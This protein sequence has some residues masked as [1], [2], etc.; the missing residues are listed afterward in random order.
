MFENN[1]V[2]RSLI[3]LEHHFQFIVITY[4]YVYKYVVNTSIFHLSKGS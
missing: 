3:Y 1:M 2:K 4:G